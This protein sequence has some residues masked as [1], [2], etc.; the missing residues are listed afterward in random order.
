[1]YAFMVLSSVLYETKITASSI[2]NG[3]Y[4]EKSG[5]GLVYEGQRLEENLSQED[6]MLIRT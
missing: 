4:T 2:A 3:A 1:M 6:E 5:N